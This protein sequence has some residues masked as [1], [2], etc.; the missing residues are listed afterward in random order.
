VD[1]IKDRPRLAAN[2]GT[3]Y[4]HAAGEQLVHIEDMSAETTVHEANSVRRVFVE[5]GGG[6]STL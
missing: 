2:G 6:R 5:L 3:L 1:A 4:R